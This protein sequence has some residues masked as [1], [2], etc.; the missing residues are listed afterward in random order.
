MRHA[1]AHKIQRKE[2]IERTGPQVKKRIR[3]I[4]R[5]LKRK[6]VINAEKIRGR[7]NEQEAKQKVL[8]DIVKNTNEFD[9]RMQ[10]LDRRSTRMLYTLERR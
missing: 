3:D 1:R 5:L 7:K 4:V 9:K 6:K 2:S 8:S 10:E